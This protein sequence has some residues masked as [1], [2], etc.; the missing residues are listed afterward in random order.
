MF[1]KYHFI[2]EIDFTNLYT[3]QLKFCS[4]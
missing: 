4:K 3:K 2:V 1:A